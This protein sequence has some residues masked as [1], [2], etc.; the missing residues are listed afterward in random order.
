MPQSQGPGMMGQIAANAASIA[1][2][3]TMARGIGNALGWNGSSQQPAEAAAAPQSVQAPYDQNQGYA[4]QQ[5][6]QQAPNACEN[7]AK[8]FANCLTATKGDAAPCQ[9]YLDQFKACQ[10][11]A[12]PY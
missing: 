1:V 10:A 6:Q 4:Q 7:I 2:G 9:Y 11:A 3:H 8:D 12:A 5:Q